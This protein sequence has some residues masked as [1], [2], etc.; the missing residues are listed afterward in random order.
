MKNG[1]LS[2]RFNALQHPADRWQ[3]NYVPDCH[4]EASEALLRL[5][6]ISFLNCRLAVFVGEGNRACII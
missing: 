5:V 1:G 6:S 4:N 3:I 2:D